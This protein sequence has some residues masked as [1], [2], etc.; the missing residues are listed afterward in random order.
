MYGVF[1]GLWQSLVTAK[2]LKQTFKST[3]IQLDSSG[4]MV[5]A[6]AA[7]L[8][9]AAGALAMLAPARR[10]AVTDPLESLRE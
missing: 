5:Y 6:A 3:P 2:V 10:A 9:L 7:A 1:F 4:P 8:L